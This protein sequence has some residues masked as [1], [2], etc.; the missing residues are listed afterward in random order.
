M[1]GHEVKQAKWREPQHLRSSSVVQSSTVSVARFSWQGRWV[2][3]KGV[4][5]FFLGFMVFAY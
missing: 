4:P 5:L 1:E 2:E 3:N